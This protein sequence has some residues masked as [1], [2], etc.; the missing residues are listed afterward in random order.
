MNNVLT[1]QADAGYRLA[2][3]KAAQYFTSLQE[4]LLNNT[5]TT[6]LTQDIHLWQKKHIQP[7]SWL[8]F[9]SPSQRKPDSRDAHRYI[10]WLNVTGKLD[11]Y[12]DRSISYI[13]MRDLG[14]ALDSSDTQARIQRVAQAT[15]AYFIRSNT[16]HHKGSPDYISL[17][18]LYRWAQRRTWKKLLSGSSAN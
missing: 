12:L 6:A 15:K 7:F 1:D 2:E 18:A 3:Q 14:K 13:Y 16:T 8:S 17:A 10:H 9:L 4:Q 5:Y 11:D